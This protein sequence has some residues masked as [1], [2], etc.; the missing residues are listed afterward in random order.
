MKAPAGEI[1]G[2]HEKRMQRDS[3]QASNYNQKHLQIAHSKSVE[4]GSQG[5]N[6]ITIIG[7][8]IKMHII[9]FPALS[10]ALPCRSMLKSL[11]FPPVWQP[12]VFAIA[13]LFPPIHHAKEASQQTP[14]PKSRNKFFTSFGVIIIPQPAQ[15]DSLFPRF[16]RRD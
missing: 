13:I 1:V 9:A 16:H 5:K 7:P 12:V 14:Q 10:R 2:A 6:K 15:T 8:C 3:E 11:I 4:H